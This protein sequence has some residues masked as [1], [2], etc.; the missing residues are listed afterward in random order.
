LGGGSA[1][2]A[3]ALRLIND[4]LQ[5]NLSKEKLISYAMTL[6]SD[7]AF[8][9][10]DNPKLGTGRGEILEEITVS[11]K[12]KYLVLIKPDIHV[13]TAEAYAGVS[14]QIPDYSIQDVLKKFPLHEWKNV[15]KNDFEKSVFN[16]FPTI[17]TIKEQLYATG[18]AYA[19]MSGS[20]S[21]VYGIFDSRPDVTDQFP[22]MISWIGRL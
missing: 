20:G 12:G 5:L 13:S 16:K 3:F 7:C 21:A 11:L 10:Q 14:P 22:G 6:G 19:S 18:A 9:I 8:F 15:L 2:A 17:K 4:V 1:D